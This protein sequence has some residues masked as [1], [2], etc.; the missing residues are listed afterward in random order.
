MAVGTLL[1]SYLEKFGVA[2]DGMSV[3]TVGFAAALDVVARIEPMVAEAIVH[4]L[5]EQRTNLKLIASENFASP[6]CCRD[7]QLMSD[8]YAEWVPAPDCTRVATTSSRRSR[9]RDLACSL[10]GAEHAYANRTPHRRQPGRLLGGAG[11][12]RS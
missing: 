1:G 11:P 10:F 12:T 5:D 3:E 7:G 6:R 2:V 9:V 4:E 8:T